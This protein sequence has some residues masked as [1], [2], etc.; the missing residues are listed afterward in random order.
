MLYGVTTNHVTGLEV[1]TAGGEVIEVGG[2]VSG[3]ATSLAYGNRAILHAR[4][5]RR[6]E[7]V[8]DG[9]AAFAVVDRDQERNTFGGAMT[10]LSIALAELGRFE[11]A[12]TLYGA[13]AALIPIATN[14]AFGW[15]R[16]DDRV[17][18]VLGRAG[19]ATAFARGADLDRDGTLALLRAELDAVE[20]ELAKNG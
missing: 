8:I 6:R 16:I 2:T 18:S 5:G 14:D 11:G 20:S 7:A 13:A 17:V 3:L 1:V 12:A 4:A 10:H 9:R 19:F 15:Q